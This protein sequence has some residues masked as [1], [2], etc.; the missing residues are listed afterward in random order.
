MYMGSGG[1][2]FDSKAKQPEDCRHAGI[3]ELSLGRLFGGISED[4]PQVV[5]NR[6]WTNRSLSR[7]ATGHRGSGRSEI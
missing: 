4:R 6:R 1:I 2:T 7:T 3:Q 5:R